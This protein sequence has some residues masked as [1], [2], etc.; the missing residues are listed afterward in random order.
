MRPFS[1]FLLLFQFLLPASNF[2]LLVMIVELVRTLE[3]ESA[4]DE[5]VLLLVVLDV[6]E[7]DL[8]RSQFLPAGK[9]L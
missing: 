5:G 7:V 1:A 6:A 4:L 2:L 8:P 9:L 3:A